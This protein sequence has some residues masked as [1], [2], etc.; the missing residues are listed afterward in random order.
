MS[1]VTSG[2]LGWRRV[3][4]GFTHLEKISASS[5]EMYCRTVGDVMMTLRVPGVSQDIISF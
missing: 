4:K 1:S 2:T 5:A 3:C